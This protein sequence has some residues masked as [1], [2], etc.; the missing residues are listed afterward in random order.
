MENNNV[1]FI[2]RDLDIKINGCC[3]GWNITINGQWMGEY[4]PALTVGDVAEAINRFLEDKE[5]S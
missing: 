2:I 3:E 4:L 1:E 5:K